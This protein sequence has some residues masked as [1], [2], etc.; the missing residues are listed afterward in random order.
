MKT[1]ILLLM[2]ALLAIG[3]STLLAKSSLLVFLTDLYNQRSIKPQELGSMIEFPIGT[4]SS[5]GRENEDPAHRF[6]WLVNEISPKTA[7][8]NS[9]EANP[10][11][12]ANGELKYLTYCA[13]CHGTTGEINEEGFAK[14]KANEV[15]MVAPAV[16]AL[17]PHFTDGYIFK[18]IKYGGAVMPSLGYATTARDR[19]DIVNAIRKLEKAQ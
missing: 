17:T 4:V 9:R 3:A 15:G 10:E 13:V 19:W 11:S 14:T 18:K 12:L 7:T 8:R 2:I 1:R 5:D 16:I 6:D